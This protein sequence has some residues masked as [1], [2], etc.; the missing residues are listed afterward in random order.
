MAINGLQTTIRLAC[1]FFLIPWLGYIGLALSAAI[2][3]T[4]QVLALAWW[5]KS[6]YGFRFNT[7]NWGKII[8]T[9]I[10]VLF[11]LLATCLLYNVA[12]TNSPVLI[13]FLCS[14]FGALVYILILYLSKNVRRFFYGG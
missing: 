10:A 8:Q 5:I 13:I 7:S 1:N 9:T 12:K 4:V 14:I 6:T 2:G 3:L 11:A